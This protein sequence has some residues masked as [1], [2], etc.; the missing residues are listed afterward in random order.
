MSAAEELESLARDLEGAGW[1]TKPMSQWTPAE[2]AAYQRWADAVMA[3]HRKH[4][5]RLDVRLRT[6]DDP[7]AIGEFVRVTLTIDAPTLDRHR[8]VAT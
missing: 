7:E 1:R 4:P 6:V 2:R 8:D 5:G 3:D